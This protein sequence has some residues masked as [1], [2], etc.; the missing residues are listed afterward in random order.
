MPWYGWVI[1]GA[2]VFTIVALVSV[3]FGWSPLWAILTITGLVLCIIALVGMLF[4]IG[5]SIG[6]F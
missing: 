6:R 4:V 2:L 1:I 5:D 3:I